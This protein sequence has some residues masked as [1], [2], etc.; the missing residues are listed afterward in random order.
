[1]GVSRWVCGCKFV[2]LLSHVVIIILSETHIHD[3]DKCVG[4]LLRKRK[5]G[6]ILFNQSYCFLVVH[7]FFFEKN[8]RLFEYDGRV[9][10]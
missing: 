5:D 7:F 4:A 1:M 6:I 8:K 2:F 10:V 9:L 3:Q